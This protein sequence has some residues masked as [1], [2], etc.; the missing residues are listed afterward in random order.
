ML[1]ENNDTID[2]TVSFINKIAGLGDVTIYCN[3][4][5][6]LPGIWQWKLMM[7]NPVLSAAY[8]RKYNFDI[9][10]LRNVYI[11]TFTNISSGFRYMRE[12][13]NLILT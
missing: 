3:L 13:R 8:S 2:G 11:K 1:G 5:I 6:P 12:V 9:E 10:E 7:N 4:I